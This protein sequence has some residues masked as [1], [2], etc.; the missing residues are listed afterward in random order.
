LTENRENDLSLIFATNIDFSTMQ[1]LNTNTLDE[2]KYAGMIPITPEL[3]SSLGFVDELLYFTYYF[4][5]GNAYIKRYISYNDTNGQTLNGSYSVDKTETYKGDEITLNVTPDEGYE[6]DELSVK[7][8]SDNEVL[9]TDNKFIMPDEDVSVKATFKKKEY[10]VKYLINAQVVSTQTV[11]HGDDAAAPSIPELEGHTA[12]W[13]ADGKNITADTEINAVYDIKKFTV[14]FKANGETVDTQTVE[15]GKDAVLP[16]VPAKVGYNASWDKDGKNITSDTEIKALY[17]KIPA[18]TF[19]NATIE[20]D[21]FGGGNIENTADE[22]KDILPIT[23]EEITDILNGNDIKFF[24]EIKNDSKDITEKEKE[25]IASALKDEKVAVYLDIN[26]YKQIGTDEAVLVKELDDK[27]TI[28]LK[29]PDEYI[30]RDENVIREY[31]VIRLHDDKTD[32]ITPKFDSKTNI[33]TFETDRFSSYTIVY[34]DTVKNVN[35]PVT[36]DNTSLSLWIFVSIV[37]AAFVITL[38]KKT[39]A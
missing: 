37:S 28:S 25:L 23:D 19:T 34:S 9:L 11:K 33:L 30:N 2:L 13:S 32:V 12:S 7:T 4:E 14:T 10:T 31:K 26:L 17:E 39:Y 36:G 5:E 38:N 27:I 15:Y 18:G 22:I 8:A 21:N 35:S 1:I 24:I 16:D 3:G 6:L 20:T 29:I